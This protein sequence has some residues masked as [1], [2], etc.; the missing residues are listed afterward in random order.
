[1]IKVLIIQQR[2]NVLLKMTQLICIN[3]SVILE[4]NKLDIIAYRGN[5][6][7]VYDQ[8]KVDDAKIEE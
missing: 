7:A 6:L 2:N 4:A 1:M 8:L 5:N 3:K